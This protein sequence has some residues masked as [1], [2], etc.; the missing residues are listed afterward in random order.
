M[1][2]AVIEDEPC[3]REHLI[4]LIGRVRPTYRLAFE[5][6]TI[7]ETARFFATPQG[8]Q[9]EL[10]FM[11]IELNDG[12]SFE[13]FERVP[14]WFPV[15]FTTAY[16]EYAIQAF[17]VNSIDYLL[18]PL[19]AE[20]VAAALTKLEKLQSS[21]AK[22]PPPYDKLAQRERIL[23][24]AGDHF[25]SV[26]VAEVAWLVSRDKCICAVMQDGKERLTRFAN[27]V[28]AGS[29]LDPRRFFQL[30]R[31]MIVNIDNIASVTRHFNSRLKVEVR[32]GAASETVMVSSAM[33]QDFLDWMA[34]NI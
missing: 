10:A 18:K 32:A 13:I 12:K 27:L 1:R 21:G 23:T 14:I 16:D 34:D 17:K 24:V 26:R 5:A 15:I 22:M 11:D 29:R 33:R 8:R 31:Y 4:K 28:E 30:S 3:A 2:Y 9:T 7:Q 20:D 19:Q 6:D 25:A